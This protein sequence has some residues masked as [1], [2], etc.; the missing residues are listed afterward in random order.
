MRQWSVWHLS[1]LWWHRRVEVSIAWPEKRSESKLRVRKT[2]K[3]SSNA[4]TS[5]PHIVLTTQKN[6][7]KTRKLKEKEYWLT[8]IGH[9]SSIGS[10]ALMDLSRAQ[11]QFSLSIHRIN[12]LAL[13]HTHTHTYTHTEEIR[14]ISKAEQVS[15]KSNQTH[16]HTNT[17]IISM[18]L[19][20]HNVML[21]SI[22]FSILLLLFRFDFRLVFWCCEFIYQSFDFHMHPM[23]IHGAL[24]HKWTF[25]LYSGWSLSRFHPI[26]SDLSH[27]IYAST[28]C[29]WLQI[30][31]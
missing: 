25:I 5:H 13:T 31:L 22:L 26:W 15:F 16:T 14:K 24:T 17:N 28:Q 11:M 7:N 1:Y 23:N 4:R 9:R 3:K 18:P 29:I 30:L 8:T 6:V 12:R 2:V 10:E 27:H 21:T 19:S 20:I